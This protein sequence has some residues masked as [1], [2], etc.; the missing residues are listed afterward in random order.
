MINQTDLKYFVEVAKSLHLTRAAERL[1]VTQPALSHCLKRLE[2]ETKTVLFIRSKKGVSLTRSG[3]RLADQAI[4]LIEK[5]NAVVL[6]AQNEVQEVSGTIR[7]GC[8]TAVAQY[9]LS[10]FVPNFLQKYPAINLQF[11]HALSRHLAEDVISQKLDAAF[12][13][14]PIAHPDLIIK[15]ISKDRVTL[16]R[17][18][19]CV[20]PDVLIV[21]PSLLQTQDLLRKLQKKGIRF[22]R[23]IESSSLEV[24][25]QLVNSGAGC[26]ILPERVIRALSDQN[27]I[28]IKEAP[29]FHDRMCLIYKSEF[30]KSMRGQALIQAIVQ[31]LTS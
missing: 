19:N 8:H 14:N 30:R 28:T 1:G 6:A 2:A 7:F 12:V 22:T 13:V 3:Q 31:S 24:I 18:K 21:E 26:G 25:S 20:N 10:H 9:T 11:S 17:A 29:E 23:I 27:I 15:E 16:W 5:W 4:E